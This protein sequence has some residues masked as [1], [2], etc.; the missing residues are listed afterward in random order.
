VPDSGILPC[1]RHVSAAAR[2]PPV[3]SWASPMSAT[4][5]DDDRAAVRSAD[6]ARLDLVG[7]AVHGPR[8][9]VD[10]TVNGRL[11]LPG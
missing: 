7:L 11:A 5:N 6:P 1:A 3:I 8:D 10:V 9:G 2:T 4:G